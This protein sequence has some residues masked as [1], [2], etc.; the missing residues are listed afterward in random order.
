MLQHPLESA[1]PKMLGNRPGRL[2]EESPLS[3]LYRLRQAVSSR[4]LW[5]QLGL[6]RWLSRESTCFVSDKT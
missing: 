5:L 6:E 2:F 3:I 1:S 4:V